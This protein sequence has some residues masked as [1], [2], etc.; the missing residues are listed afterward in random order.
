MLIIANQLYYRDIV[1]FTITITITVDYHDNLFYWIG[2]VV[3]IL[4]VLCR[5]TD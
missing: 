5:A 3:C 4:T 1:M 2:F